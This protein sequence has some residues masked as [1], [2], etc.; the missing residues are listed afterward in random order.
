MRANRLTYS[1]NAGFE[2]TPLKIA[3]AGAGAAG[4]CLAIK[5]LEAQKSGKLGPVDTVVFER[6]E[7]VFV[8]S[9]VTCGR[10]F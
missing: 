10:S 6:A 1:A 7:G 2:R 8:F 3:I 4:I 5:I 9:V